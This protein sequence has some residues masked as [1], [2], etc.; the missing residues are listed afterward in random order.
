MGQLLGKGAIRSEPGLPGRGRK[1]PIAIG[2]PSMA[3]RPLVGRPSLTPAAGIR[4]RSGVAR[5]RGGAAMRRSARGLR[6]GCRRPP[7]PA[8]RPTPGRVMRSMIPGGAFAV[9]RPAGP[10]QVRRHPAVAVAP[11]PAGERDDVRRRRCLVVPAQRRLPPGGSTRLA[12]S[13]MLDRQAPARGA[14]SMACGPCRT[15]SSRVSRPSCLRLFAITARCVPPSRGRRTRS[16]AIA[17]STGHGPVAV[18]PGD[19]RPNGAGHAGGQGRMAPGATGSIPAIR[20]TTFTGLRASIRSSQSGARSA[21]TALLS[22]ARADPGHGPEAERSPRMPV[23]RL[24]ARRMRPP[25][26]IDAM[27]PKGGLGRTEADGDRLVH[28]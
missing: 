22:P 24:A 6:R 28:G 15:G 26:R 2:P 4:A 25:F 10:A 18:L 11:V 1:R 3:L 27:H 8:A 13:H 17:V 21:W 19:E 14:R 5:C 23:P 16:A 9:H 12:L 7:D 20:A